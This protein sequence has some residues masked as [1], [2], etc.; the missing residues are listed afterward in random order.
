MKKDF[1]ALSRFEK[2]ELDAIF[3]LTRDL[4]KKQKAGIEH[5]LLKGKTLAMIFEKNST[6]T[7]ISFEVG[8]YQLGG[9]PLFISGKDSQIGRGEPIQDTARCISRYCDGVMIRTFAQKTVE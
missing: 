9:H 4:K 1:L 5:H 6:R 8:F 7:R 2:S 3:T